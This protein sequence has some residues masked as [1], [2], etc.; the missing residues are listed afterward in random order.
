MY[1]KNIHPNPA[2]SRQLISN[3]L[4]KLDASPETHGHKFT[5]PAPNWNGFVSPRASP[6]SQKQDNR[7]KVIHVK[8]KST[9]NKSPP[10]S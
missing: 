2:G 1:H 6:K 7:R 5:F 9:K 3:A 10:K 4:K 8:P